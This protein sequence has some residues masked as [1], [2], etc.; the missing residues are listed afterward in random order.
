MQY[1]FRRFSI[2]VSN[3]ELFNNPGLSLGLDCTLLDSFNW[4]VTLAQ[5]QIDNGKMGQEI[6]LGKNKTWTSNWTLVLYFIRKWILQTGCIST[7]DTIGYK[8][9]SQSNR[10]EYELWL[11]VCIY[12]K[13]RPHLKLT[14]N[15]CIKGC[16]KGISE[17]NTAFNCI[18]TK[19]SRLNRCFFWEL[20]LTAL[21]FLYT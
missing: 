19:I 16:T 13:H 1:Q 8:I 17:G 10:H 6:G 3:R 11:N 15:K 5:A 14:L 12:R 20:I 21:K 9:I 7:G 18:F 2:P 4:T